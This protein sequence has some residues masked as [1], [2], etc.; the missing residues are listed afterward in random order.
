MRVRNKSKHKF[1]GM[2]DW[3]TV[4]GH[5]IKVIKFNMNI[6]LTPISSYL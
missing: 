5:K 3:E 6:W 1:V 2:E 4:K